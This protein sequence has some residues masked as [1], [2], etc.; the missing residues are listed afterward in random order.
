MFLIDVANGGWYNKA[1]RMTKSQFIALPGRIALRS[2]ED[3]VWNDPPQAENPAL[4]GSSC[5]IV[6]VA[7]SNNIFV[8][9]KR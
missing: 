2:K 5:V 3:V 9:V 8:S 4:Q 6:Y 7:V 1:Y